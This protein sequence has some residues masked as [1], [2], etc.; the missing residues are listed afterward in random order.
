[1]RHRRTQKRGRPERVDLHPD[2][3]YVSSRKHRSRALIPRRDHHHIKQSAQVSHLKI[4]F[5]SPKFRQI[6]C[7]K[8]IP[9]WQNRSRYSHLLLAVVFQ[10]QQQLP[11]KKNN[12][13]IWISWISKLSFW[14]CLISQTGCIH[15]IT[16]NLQ[17]WHQLEVILKHWRHWYETTWH[18]LTI[19]SREQK[20]AIIHKIRFCSWWKFWKMII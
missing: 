2:W 14:P 5:A 18:T 9:V 16:T 20:K 4:N 12:Y 15:P 3:E 7:S 19:R 17:D 8:S 13:K 11:T 6:C 1:M 10:K